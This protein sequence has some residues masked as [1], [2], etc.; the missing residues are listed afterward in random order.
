MPSL[1]FVE[2]LQGEVETFRNLEPK[3]MLEETK[4][5]MEN[6]WTKKIKDGLGSRPAGLLASIYWTRCAATSAPTTTKYQTIISQ[7]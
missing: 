5:N 2:D 7:K 1:Q 6:V 4:R 3:S